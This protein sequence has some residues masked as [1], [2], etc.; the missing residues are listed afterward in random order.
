MNWTWK[1]FIRHLCHKTYS[2]TFLIREWWQ[3]GEWLRVSCT[4]LFLLPRC[5][6]VAAGFASVDDSKRHHPTRVHCTRG[7]LVCLNKLH[8]TK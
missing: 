1:T 3:S 4:N 6:Q 5:R 2:I 7:V 8:V